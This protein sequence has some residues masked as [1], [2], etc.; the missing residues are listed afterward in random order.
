MTWFTIG[1]LYELSQMFDFGFLEVF[2]CV[3]GMTFPRERKDV[4]L[5]NKTS[6]QN[7]LRY[8]FA[9]APLSCDIFIFFASLFALVDLGARLQ[10]RP[11][12][13]RTEFAESITPIPKSVL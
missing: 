8:M 3:L 5:S 1:S 6:F 12:E 10:Q 7:I 4:E 13:N 9:I 11:N 2:R